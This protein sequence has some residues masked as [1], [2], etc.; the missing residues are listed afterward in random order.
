MRKTSVGDVLETSRNWV[1]NKKRLPIFLIITGLLA[2]LW[3]LIRVVPKPVRASYPCQRA[4]FPIASGFVLWIIGLFAFKPAL[5]K[6]KSGF[7]NKPFIGSLLALFLISGYLVWTVSIFNIETKASNIDPETDYNFV[8]APSNKPVGDA[9]GV[10]P[11]RV[12]W[13][14]NPKAT[15][16]QGNWKLDSDQWWL[17][18]NTDQ[19]LVDE[20]LVE[21]I[22]KLTG[23]K[24]LN[25]AWKKIFTYYNS[26]TRGLANTT[27]KPG[28]TI[29][30]KVNINN[31]EGPN[32]TNNYSDVSPQIVLSLVRQL[33]NDA[34]VAQSDI[35][36]FDS[37]RFM[38]PYML[39]KVWSEFKDV[40]FVQEGAP[41]EKQPINPAYG[42]HQG[43]EATIWVK[44]L[45]YSKGSFDKAC[46][47]P[48]QVYDATY[49][50]NLAM[51]KS[52]SYPYN[53]MEDGDEGQTGITICG[54]NH[55]GSIQ[56]PFELHKAINPKDEAK[57][58]A[59]S[60]FVDM[61][62]S[63][64]LGGKTILFLVDGLY[65]G[66]KWRTYPSHFPNAPFN[67][68]LVPYENQ[69]WPASILASLDGVAMDCVG[70]DILNAQSKNNINEFGHRRIML[71]TISG[72]YLL[73]M[74]QAENPPS[75]TKYLQNNKPVK[76]LGVFEHWDSD[77]TRRYSRNID[78][79]NGKGIELIY[80]HL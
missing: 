56:G 45:T 75:G 59:Y 24:K 6:I 9:K 48:K 18:K 30:I 57:P 14:H 35:V 55:F 46:N 25:K 52:H 37:K 42:N 15:K 51:L 34:G 4:A 47:I 63:P 36:V 11:G 64:N 65:A 12:V 76:S 72:D 41:K 31:T 17:D 10:Y 68:T 61:A 53:T 23:E 67:N 29:A 39:T 2:T 73:E 70:L 8:P 7:A 22:G 32:K 26:T 27:Y 50:I 62:A 33:V 78:P 43:L 19:Q 79:K 60:P 21:T 44:E 3:F 66:R 69:T 38:H 49:L 71:Q 16:W 77:E 28:E 1:G 13:A 5:V 74:A 40:R 20:M 54:K 80:S 58:N